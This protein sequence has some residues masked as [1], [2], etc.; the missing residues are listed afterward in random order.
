MA[1]A[2]VLL[3]TVRL[4]LGVLNYVFLVRG[5]GTI[6]SEYIYISRPNK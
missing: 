6:K 4:V 5:S 3:Y 2:R 1:G